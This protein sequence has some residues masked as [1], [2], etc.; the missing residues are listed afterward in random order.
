MIPKTI[1]FSLP[2]IDE[3]DIAEVVDTLKSGWITTGPKVARFEMEFARFIGVPYALALNSA[4]A[5]LHLALEAIHIQP[6]EK[7]ITTPFTFAATAEVIQY[8][9]ADPIFIDIE[10]KNLNI[11]PLKIQKFCEEE[12][13]VE[14]ERL[15][16][17]K[18]KR[19]IRAIIPVHIG[20]CVCDMEP[21]LS[22]AKKY[23]LVVIEDA[24]HALPSHYQG[25]RVGT[26]SDMTVFSFYP[27]KPI[28]TGEGGMVVTHS[29]Q[30]FECMKIKSLHGIDK[31]AWKRT[32]AKEEKFWY[33][34][35]TDLGYKYNMTDIAASLGLQ[36]LKKLEKFFEK[37][38]EI[39]SFYQESLSSVEGIVLPDIASP[40]H[41]WHLYIIQVDHPRLTRDSLIQRLL[42][43]GIATGVHFIPLHLH[44]FYRKKYGFL[45]EDYPVATHC[46]QRIISLPIYTRLGPNEMQKIVSSVKEV[47]A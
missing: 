41:S 40:G 11:D 17:R 20:G 44:P 31:D 15:I 16:H 8:C 12:C 35:I 37:R 21:I 39:A 18:D 5:G 34:E 32:S 33:Y 1:P 24:S 47:L 26:L 42:Q 38:N 13:G 10:P 19:H 28:T 14:G 2:D 36:Q 3:E 22:I 9:G 6:D 7:V 43:K 27:T 46:F 4:T 25:K 29:K 23:N 45:P 30:Y